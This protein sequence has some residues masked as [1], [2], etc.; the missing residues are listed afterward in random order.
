MANYNALV[1]NGKLEFPHAGN[2][3]KWLAKN[4]GLWITESVKL[5]HPRAK[6][7]PQLGI[8]WGLWLPEITDAMNAAGQRITIQAFGRDIEIEYSTDTMH[9]LLTRVAGRVGPGGEFMRL[10]EMGLDEAKLFLNGVKQFGV[11]NL[12]MQEERLEAWRR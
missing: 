6:S 7:Q 3:L 11:E 2:R 5:V 8:Y 10:S 12:G 4:E 9:E 1:R